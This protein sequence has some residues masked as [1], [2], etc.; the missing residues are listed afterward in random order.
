M[1]KLSIFDEESNLLKESDN[2]NTIRNI[3]KK[4][5]IIFEQ[6][7]SSNCSSVKSIEKTYQKEIKKIMSEGG[8]QSFDIV[9]LTPEHPDKKNLRNKF[10]DE[11]THS[12]DEVRFFAEGSGIFFLHLHNKVYRLVCEQKD[13]ISIPKNT[14]HWFDMGKEPFFIAI[15]F[16]TNKEGWVA[17]FS[18]NNIASKFN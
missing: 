7:S 3:L 15:R 10:L 18:G 6:W 11:H 17:N 13:L 16:F 14:L 9:S 8:Y 12:E 4:E 1:K 2:I 5:E